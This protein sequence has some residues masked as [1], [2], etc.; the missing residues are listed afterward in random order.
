MTK[1]HLEKEKVVSETV[2]KNG[3]EY[4]IVENIREQE[5]PSCIFGKRGWV[6]K[7]VKKIE[8]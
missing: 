6:L 1:K 3:Y 4:T 5:Y 7:S 8:K 2:I